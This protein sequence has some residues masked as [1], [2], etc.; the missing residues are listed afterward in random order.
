VS[1]GGIP[2][3]VPGG[4]VTPWLACAVIAFMLTSIRAGEW[5]ALGITLVIASLIYS[6]TRVSRAARRGA[7][8]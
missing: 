4:A 6:L 2:F 5:A 1:Q 8:A 7:V 3:R